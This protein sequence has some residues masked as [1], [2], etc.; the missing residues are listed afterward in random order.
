MITDKGTEQAAGSTRSYGLDHRE[1]SIWLGYTFLAR[2]YWGGGANTEI[3]QSQLAFLFGH[4]AAV[5]FEIGENNIRSQKALKRF[6]VEAIERSEQGL[7][8]GNLEFRPTREAFRG[9]S[10]LG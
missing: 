10:L 9:R 6:G 2:P 3:K 5:Y 8:K 7:K 1:R 4:V